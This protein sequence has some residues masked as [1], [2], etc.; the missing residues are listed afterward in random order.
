MIVASQDICL[1]ITGNGDIIEP[2][3]GVIAIGSGSAYATGAARAL[4]D[5][6]G[7][8]ASDIAYKAMQIA[9]DH[10]IYTNHSFSLEKLPTINN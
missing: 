8:D 7:W 10:C 6:D 5:L 1:Q 2:L 4:V 3:D 9:A